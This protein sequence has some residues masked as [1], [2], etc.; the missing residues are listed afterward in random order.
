MNDS[1]LI[2]KIGV[3]FVGNFSSKIFSAL[4]IPIYAFYVSSTDLGYF[5]YYQSIMLMMSPILVVAIWEAILKF[6][7][8]EQLLEKKNEVIRTG[9]LFS[10]SSLLFSY[11]VF[12]ILFLFFLRSYNSWILLITMIFFYSLG[13]IWL[14]TA[15][16]MQKNFDFAMGGVISTVAN[17]LFIFIFLIIFDFG[18]KG[19]LS[20]FI[21]GQLILIIYLERKIKIFKIAFSN[22]GYDF[23]LLK[24]MLK[25]SAPLVLNLVSIWG[26]SSFGRFIIIHYLGADM[27]GI[28]SFANKFSLIVNMLGTI[29]NMA[30]IEEALI[31]NNDE[32]FR[33]KFEKQV[34]NMTKIF[35]NFCLILIPVIVIFYEFL[36]KTEYEKSLPYVFPLIIYAILNIIST[37]VATVYQAKEKTNILFMTTIIGALVNVVMSFVLINAFGIWSVIIAQIFGSFVMLISR[38][39]LAKIK[40]HIGF[41]WKDFIIAVVV[42]SVVGYVSVKSGPIFNF[43]LG[44]AL[45]IFYFIKYKKSF[46]KIT[47]TLRKGENK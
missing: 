5:D 30:F 6:V 8:N 14:Y 35:L 7:L 42:Y 36:G 45:L 23:S 12:F 31:N 3:Y 16:A 13:Q 19:L 9:I 27:N 32:N 38:T 33:E 21:L 25:Y 24:R 20:S 47:K 17:L 26:L 40:F 29:V 39:L 34:N 11:S 18:L 28:Y 41:G 10:L 43:I 1:S 2:R 4:L 44:L 15:R 22:S 37:N 46:L